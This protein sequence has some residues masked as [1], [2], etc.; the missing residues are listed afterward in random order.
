MHLD[1]Y[2]Q[3]ILNDNQSFDVGDQSLDLVPDQKMTIDDRKDKREQ[4]ISQILKNMSESKQFNNAEIN[5]KK[6]RRHRL[7]TEGLT[8]EEIKQ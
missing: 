5:N 6:K 3:F 8:A 2:L 7:R 4:V 1:K